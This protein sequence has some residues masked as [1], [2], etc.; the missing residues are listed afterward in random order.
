[1][2]LEAPEKY[3]ALHNALYAFKGQITPDIVLAHL[4]DMGLDLDS[5]QKRAQSD[6]VTSLIQKNMALAQKLGIEGTP[7]FVVGDSV[8]PGYIEGPQLQLA[9]QQARRGC[10][11]C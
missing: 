1:M 5:I 9:I 4:R 8:I 7:A 6:D 10:E 11:S 3:E 2:F